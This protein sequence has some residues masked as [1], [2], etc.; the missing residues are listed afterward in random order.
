M[1][2][3][4][5]QFVTLSRLIEYNLPFVLK[6][7]GAFWLVHI[8][9]AALG[10]RLCILGIY[11]RSIPGLL[12]VFFSP[13]L[14]GNFNHIFFNSI[15]LIILSSLLM[16]T[17]IENFLCVTISIILLSGLGVWLFAR[18]VFHVGASGLIVGYWSYLVVNA[19]SHP[20]LVAVLLAF[21]S[22]YYFGGIFFSILPG[23]EGVSWEAHLSGFI[24]GIA[25]V[26]LCP[27]F[28]VQLLNLF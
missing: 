11:P 4:V 20:S 15:P 28:T 21:V 17:G 7:L 27:A 23:E 26:Y 13:F 9:N 12:G 24:A 16:L 19:Y 1:Q 5:D 3:Y 18:K 8:L 25:A 2:E 10:Y 22:I 14:H 6:F